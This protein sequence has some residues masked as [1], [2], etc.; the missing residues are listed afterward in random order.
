MKGESERVQ[1]EDVMKFWKI[2]GLPRINF[3][4]WFSVHV[5]YTFTMNQHMS[6]QCPLFKLSSEKAINFE[7]AK[8][9]SILSDC[10]LLCCT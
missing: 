8:N 9:Y 6:Y 4:A 7:K 5:I 2:P 3:L 10:P 1:K